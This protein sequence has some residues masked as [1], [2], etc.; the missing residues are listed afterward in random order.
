[1]FNY[2]LNNNYVDSKRAYEQNK[3]S[4]QDI[5]DAQFSQWNH[6]DDVKTAY[7]TLYKN[8]SNSIFTN[9]KFLNSEEEENLFSQQYENID[10]A[11]EELDYN[12]SFQ[13]GDMNAIL[14]QYSQDY[15]ND[16]KLN[17]DTNKQL[18]EE[19]DNEDKVN[20]F[21]FV[22]DKVNVIKNYFNDNEELNSQDTDGISE[23]LKK[24]KKHKRSDN[25]TGHEEYQQ[26]L[27]DEAYRKTSQDFYLTKNMLEY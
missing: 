4:K 13:T 11:L 10:E 19:S 17:K 7:D 8:V 12:T 9:K 15:E 26:S 16:S 1:M 18:F 23:Q 14:A 24:M 25:I 20:L 22:A 2:Q 21:N 5:N 3:L 6:T 27:L